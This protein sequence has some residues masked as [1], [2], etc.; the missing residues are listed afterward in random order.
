M[1]N[2]AW[3]SFSNI[4]LV[5]NYIKNFCFLLQ[6]KHA[7]KLTKPAAKHTATDVVQPTVSSRKKYSPTDPKQATFI[8]NIPVFLA[9]SFSIAEDEGFKKLISDIEPRIVCPSRYHLSTKL[10]PETSANIHRKLQLLLRQP[11]IS[12][13]LWTSGQT[14]RCVPSSESL[15]TSSV[16]GNYEVL[17]SPAGVSQ[18]VIQLI[19]SVHNM[20]RLSTNSTLRTK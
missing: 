3:L 7:D 11:R 10:I 15:P 4:I 18:A 5:Y 16:T 19:T 17:C 13:S 1:L 6:R 14:D 9:G 2:F 20:R 8:K 12:L